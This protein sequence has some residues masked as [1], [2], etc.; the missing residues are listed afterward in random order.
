VFLHQAAGY[1]PCSVSKKKLLL[2]G[3]DAGD[4]FSTTAGPVRSRRR[5]KTSQGLLGGGTKSTVCSEE[6]E[7]ESSQLPVFVENVLTASYR[8]PT[9]KLQTTTTTTT[10]TYHHHLCRRSRLRL[11][12]RS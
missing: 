2:G 7:S 6:E 5:A 10:T 12:C 9:K 8:S 4:Q 3:R 11:T 1:K